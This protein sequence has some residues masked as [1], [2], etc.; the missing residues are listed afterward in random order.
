VLWTDGYC[1]QASQGGSLKVSMPSSN[2]GGGSFT[3][4]TTFTGAAFRDHVFGR[5][6]GNTSIAWPRS[7]VVPLLGVIRDTHPNE[8]EIRQAV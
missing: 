4:V 8:N 2:K 1:A 6:C 3:P 7:M 5:L